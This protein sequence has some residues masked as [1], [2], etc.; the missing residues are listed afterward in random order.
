MEKKGCYCDFFW[1]F[2]IDHWKSK[3]FKF[4]IYL[5]T[6]EMFQSWKW[7]KQIA[8]NGYFWMVILILTGSSDWYNLNAPQQ[9]MT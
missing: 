2:F 4:Y 3:D 8:M 7:T 1:F 5:R 6:T 9:I